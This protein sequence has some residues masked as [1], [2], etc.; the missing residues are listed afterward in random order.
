MQRQAVVSSDLQSV[1]YD[2]ASRVLEIEF[3]NNTV[4]QYFGVPAGEHRGLMSAASHG[5]YLHAH[6]KNA[7]PYERV[8]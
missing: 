5:K 3:K 1:G 7:Y 4:Y 8:R 6:I 2:E